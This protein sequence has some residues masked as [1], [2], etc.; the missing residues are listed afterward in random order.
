MAGSATLGDSLVDDL[1]PL[2]DDLFSELLPMAGIRQW[3]VFAVRRTW[4]SG[5][6]GIAGLVATRP[7]IAEIEILPPPEVS[8]AGSTPGAFTAAAR[9]WEMTQGGRSPQCDAILSAVSL[10]YTETELGGGS[11]PENVEFYYRLVD[12]KG[13]GCTP[14]YFVPAGQPAP[15]RARTLGWIV[16]L[17]AYDITE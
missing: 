9:T 15:D 11:I 12:G 13:Q 4:P 6:R 16:P 5:Q 14:R 7:Q 8:L 17:V 10:T 3:R 2:V 1:V